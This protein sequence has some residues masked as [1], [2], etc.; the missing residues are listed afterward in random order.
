MGKPA[1][2]LRKVLGPFSMFNGV[3]AVSDDT[4]ALLDEAE[5]V[6][7]E[8]DLLEDLSEPI[9]PGEPSTYDDPTAINAVRASMHALLAKL[10][11]EQ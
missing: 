7:G 5:R 6:L 1:D 10:R 11:G 4:C 2:R 3:T 8:F 9:K